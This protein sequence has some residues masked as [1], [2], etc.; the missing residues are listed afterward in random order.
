[1]NEIDVK[2]DFRQDSKCGDPD[3]DSQKLY[4]AHKFLWSKELPNGKTF[5]LEIKSNSYGRLI[6][7]NNL[8]MN[9]SSDRM[10]PHF[11]G[12]YQNKFKGWLSEMER[13]EL[14]FKVRTIGGHIVFPAH[15]KNG[16][17]I[18]QARGVNRIICDRFDLTLECIRRL[19][20]DEE[21]PLSK[22][23]LNYKDFFELFVDFKGYIEFFHLKDFIN[24]NEQ[25][26]FSLPFDN[27]SRPALPQTI[28]EYRQYKNHTINLINKRN[29]RILKK[30]MDNSI[31]KDCQ[32]STT[33]KN[34]RKKT[35]FPS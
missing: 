2:F 31:Y 35:L 30:L 10:C 14:K 27:F 20:R 8:C 28:D 5:L 6:I 13:E 1:M 17:T 25:I 19:Y 11:D 3:T 9:L 24:Q 15:K 22:T 4:N 7:K 18:N 34:I 26:E 12:K 23:L 29:K 32:F 16:F 33:S 21:S